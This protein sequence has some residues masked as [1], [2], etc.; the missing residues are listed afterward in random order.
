NDPSANVT[1]DGAIATDKQALLPGETA[2]FPNYTSYS[3]GINGIIVDVASLPSGGAVTAADFTF[4]I[5]NDDNPDAWSL[6][7]APN[8]ILVRPGAGANGSTRIDITWADNAI[9]DT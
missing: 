5:G 6:A 4:T 3:K 7:P 1:D 2:T 8:A 9:Q